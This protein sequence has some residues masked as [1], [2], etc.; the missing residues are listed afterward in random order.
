MDVINTPMY[1]HIEARARSIR[2]NADRYEFKIAEER[3]ERL[4][5]TQEERE[6]K[7]KEEKNEFWEGI[8]I[9]FK[10]FILITFTIVYIVYT[11]W[12]GE[13]LFSFAG[14]VPV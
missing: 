6:K 10:I 4:K 5:H 12:L 2:L 14:I 13:T 3:R 1:D 9:L 11:I 8:E 7:E